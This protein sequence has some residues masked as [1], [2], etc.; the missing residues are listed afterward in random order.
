MS[1]FEPRIVKETGLDAKIVELVEPAI[2]GLGFRLIWVRSFG[3]PTVTVQVV[4]EHPD[5]WVN[6]GDC[7]S[8]SDDLISLL[9]L[10]YSEDTDCNLEVSSPGVDRLLVRRSDFSCWSGREVKVTLSQALDDRKRLCGI[11]LGCRDGELGVR[12][13][14]TNAESLD[15]WFPETNLAQA[16]LV[17]T[18]DLIAEGLRAAKQADDKPTRQ[19]KSKRGNKK[20]PS[21]KS[22]CF[23]S[24]PG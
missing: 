16:R 21:S 2:E 11:L 19:R 10:I 24:G 9:D 18:E 1:R 22:V 20:S 8:V 7:Q 3:G 4:L 12:V 23:A 6:I 17:L 14:N 5:R 15:V 13:K